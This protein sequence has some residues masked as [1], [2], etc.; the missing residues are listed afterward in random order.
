MFHLRKNHEYVYLFYVAHYKYLSMMLMLI[1]MWYKKIHDLINNNNKKFIE[2]KKTCNIKT[3]SESTILTILID[4]DPSVAINAIR[5]A[6]FRKYIRDN[7]EHYQIKKIH[8]LSQ[9]KD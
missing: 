3:F 4:Q 9:F 5:A 7:V 6:M 2:Q 1:I 8:T